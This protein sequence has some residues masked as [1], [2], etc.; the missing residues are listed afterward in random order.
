MDTNDDLMKY[1][2][3]DKSINNTI[4]EKIILGIDLGTT[5]SCISVWRNN[6]CEI[7][8]DE[9]GN[10]TIPSYVS[11]TNVSK[12]VGIDAKRQKDINTEN[13]FYEVKRLI[14]RTYDDKSVQD[15][16]KLLSY[17]IVENDRGCISLQSTIKNNKQFT[18]EEISS[19]ILIKLKD[20]ATKYLNKEIKDVVITVPA[21]FNDT[22]R[23]A[24]KD[25]ATIAGLNCIRMFHE[26]TAAALAYGLVERTIGKDTSMNILVYDFGGG[27]LDVSL[28][29]ICNGIFDVKGTSG[30]SQFGGVDFDNRLIKFCLAKFAKNNDFVLENLSC[31]SLQK[32]RTQCENSKK[33]LSTNMSSI[34][35]VENF[36]N[37]IDLLVKITRSDFENICR[38]LFLLCMYPVDELLN[39]CDSNVDDVDEVILIGGMTRM[40]YIR[41]LLDT[42]F[43]AKKS[44]INCSINP[45]EAVSVGASIQGYMLANQN[46]NAF[47]DAVTLLDVTP[48]TLGVEVNGGI[49]DTIIK[50]NTMIPCEKTKLY[51][52]VDDNID[53]IMIKIF[54][55]ERV[56]TEYNCKIGEFCLE[57]L[58][59]T[60]KGE[61]EIE[62][63]FSID[64]NG[65]VTVK[66]HERSS[67]ENK[68]I[69]VNT[70]KNG[71]K[72]N[73]IKLLVDEA[74]EQ[75]TLDEINRTKTNCYYE[76]EELCCNI[77]S[78]LSNTNFKLTESD[79]TEMKCDVESIN[80]WLKT[81]K[82]KNHDLDEY[83]SILN[84]IK[85]KYGVLILQNTNEKQNVKAVS[86]EIDATLIHTKDCDDE[87][88]ELKQAYE[89]IKTSEFDG[90]SDNEINEINNL[91]SSLID[92]CQSISHMVDSNKMNISDS[93]K[94]EIQDYIND[95]ILWYYSHE[96]P[97]KTDYKEK[98]DMV[99]I[100]CDEIVEKY[101]EQN[102]EL[103]IQESVNDRDE[104]EKLTLML[105][106]T[107]NE[108][109]ITCSNDHMILL[110]EKLDESVKYL[111][112]DN[113]EHNNDK[114]LIK[115]LNEICDMIY[116]SMQN[117][118]IKQHGPI[119]N[120]N[121]TEDLGIIYNESKI[122]NDDKK[123]MTLMELIKM[124]QQSEIEDIINRD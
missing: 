96:K 37:N 21:H 23:Q 52:T 59:K 55:G 12:Y 65:I 86:E 28:I 31:L 50:R 47:S 15:C 107:L 117:I 18:P 78:N 2:D 64:I 61:L 102:K 63:C 22:Q 101:N 40:P 60:K 106:T 83:E 82:P 118:N 4:E 123:G 66:A 114:Q 111:Y 69:I 19:M 72:P 112:A 73:E 53:T 76:I 124:K 1:F 84:K 77:L 74:R 25:A 9:F 68:T 7:I 46:D 81:K 122:D 70:N 87:E 11:F 32:L 85:K 36:Y 57:N 27:T 30:N 98:I 13:V 120:K 99:N 89:K 14:G 8:P 34:I 116:N 56:M 58:P 26:P 41:E 29:E 3:E 91:K 113:N 35:I 42:K 88:D 94:Q 17:N 105:L 43:K 92:L 6:K 5:N 16:K 33:I 109:Q 103:F 119:I 95:I 45:D 121:L 51:T 90:M 20:M 110:T 104:L 39:E 10:K 49:M 44:K 54:E 38:D 79:I 67:N 71:L 100:L 62:I 97:T 48:L 93:H 80:I 24:T 108:K 75:E 115:E